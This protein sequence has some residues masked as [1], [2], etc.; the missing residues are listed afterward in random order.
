M[1]S[2]NVPLRVRAVLR[3]PVIGDPNLPLDSILFALVTRQDLGA[4]EMTISG[5]SLLAEPKGTPN[6]GTPVPLARVHAKDWYYRSSW[7][8][9][10]AFAD[11]SDAWTK[12]VDQSLAYLVDFRGRRG[13]INIS[14][15]EYKGYHMPVFYRAALFVEWYCVGDPDAI[16]ALL[17]FATH[18]GKKPTQ[19]WGRVAEWTVAEIDQ[20][21]SVWKDG[22][23][24]RGIPP[25]HNDR[26]RNP[27]RGLY[28]VRPPYWDQR[29]QMELVLP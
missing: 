11:G 29:N 14:S 27:K 6:R 20:D 16:R 22:V 19:G 18:L 1:S 25:Y 3:T 24:M 5:A 10:G 13:T 26:L 8:Q 12:R 15:G 9:W 7:A 4:Q 21:W 23:L 28:G 2:A 17:P